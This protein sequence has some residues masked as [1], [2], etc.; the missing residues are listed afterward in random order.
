MIAH[1]SEIDIDA[2]MHLAIEHKFIGD[3]IRDLINRADRKT[4]D[5]N[6][7][8]KFIIYIA[9]PERIISQYG[10]DVNIGQVRE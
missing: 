4:E 6:T 1:A 10:P 3:L 5:L 8:L 2:A 9:E 7:L